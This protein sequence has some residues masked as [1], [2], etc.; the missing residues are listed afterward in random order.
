MCTKHN[1]Q[2]IWLLIGGNDEEL[3]RNAKGTRVPT[4]PSV[5]QQEGAK[6]EGGSAGA[7]LPGSAGRERNGGQRDKV[8]VSAPKSGQP[9]L[10]R[11]ARSRAGWEKKGVPGGFPPGGSSKLACTKMQGD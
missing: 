2:N 11:A 7:W 3:S 5:S 8:P 10:S 9:A 1:T 6:G 4:Y